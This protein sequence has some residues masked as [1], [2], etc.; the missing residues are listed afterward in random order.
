MTWSGSPGVRRYRCRAAVMRRAD[1]ATDPFIPST[2]TTGKRCLAGKPQLMP[3]VANKYSAMPQTH[4]LIWR[5]SVCRR[6]QCFDRPKRWNQF[7]SNLGS[8]WLS[9]D[10]TLEDYPN[11]RSPILLPCKHLLK[12]KVVTQSNTFACGHRQNVF[13]TSWAMKRMTSV[14]LRLLKR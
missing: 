8:I 9:H 11:I 7:C 3:G 10:I 5:L 4:R 2:R 12:S 13:P 6:H 1:M 14:G